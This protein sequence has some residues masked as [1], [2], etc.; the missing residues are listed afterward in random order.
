MK[1]IRGEIPGYKL[2]EDAFFFAFLDA[3]PLVPGHA[4]VVPKLEVDR[5]F[6]M[7]DTYLSGILGFAKPIAEA[8]ERAYPCQRVGLS[9]VGLEVP[10]A[11]LHLVPLNSMED[12]NFTRPKMNPGP[13]ALAASQQKILRELTR[14]V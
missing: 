10:H 11:H 9:V 13:E 12:I 4:L 3:F 2:A 14:G 8:I 1:I 6:D 5:F 7:P